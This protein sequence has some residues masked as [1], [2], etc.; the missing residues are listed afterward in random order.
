MRLANLGKSSVEFL[1]EW[2]DD[3]CEKGIPTPLQRQFDDNSGAGNFGAVYKLRRIWATK[4]VAGWL[5]FLEEWFN[6]DFTSCNNCSHLS[7]S[8]CYVLFLW[9]EEHYSLPPKADAGNL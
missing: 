8:I 4:Y 5:P 7:C 6:D 3:F 9:N 2:I 1:I